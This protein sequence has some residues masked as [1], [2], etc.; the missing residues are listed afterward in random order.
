MSEYITR[1]E[2]EKL[3]LE[4]NV[5]FADLRINQPTLAYGHYEHHVFDM[6][7]KQNKLKGGDNHD[8]NG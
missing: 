3:L 2:F 4:L 1:E 8:S 7:T 5:T 6:K